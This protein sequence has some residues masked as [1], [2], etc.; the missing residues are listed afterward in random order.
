MNLKLLL[1]GLLG[2]FSC[3]APQE[4]ERTAEGSSLLKEE[5]TDGIKQESDVQD[6]KPEVEQS[7]NFLDTKT[8]LT[9]KIEILL[10]SALGIKF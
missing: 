1:F 8:V 7:D 5:K 10:P 6:Y 9:G 3:L 2:S 4:N